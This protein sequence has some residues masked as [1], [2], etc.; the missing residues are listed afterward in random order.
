MWSG[1]R[2]DAFR[3]SCRRFLE[4]SHGDRVHVGNDEPDHHALHHY[5]GLNQADI[6]LWLASGPTTRYTVRTFIVFA[7]KER[8]APPLTVPFRHAQS[9][10]RLTREN[11]LDWIR[12][13][14]E[15]D[16]GVTLRARVAALLLLLFAQ[17]LVRI[18]ELQLA[19]LDDTAGVLTI[20]FEH[21]PVVVPEPF[22]ALA[23]QQL[24][25]GAP[26]RTRELDGNTWLFPGGRAGH[27]VTHSYL[28]TEI[29]RMGINVLA[30]KNRTLD[31]LV[32]EM[33][34]ALVAD[35]LGYNYQVTELHKAN[36]GGTY[37]RYA[38]LRRD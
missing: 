33:P 27:H 21:I 25:A 1:H 32:T 10:R 31:D 6:D 36:A 17:P 22:A 9:S 7:V 23:R 14:L 26:T 8:M 35:T 38:A 3:E 5:A 15:G 29:R 37:A 24:G 16:T 11:R 2:D 34:A 30:A 18:A 13:C 20:V 4:G 12:I 19:A 28:M